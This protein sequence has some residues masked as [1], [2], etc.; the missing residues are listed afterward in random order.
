VTS[1]F[2]CTDPEATT[3]LAARIGDYLAAGDALLLHGEVGAGKSHFARGLI[4]SLL[5]DATR[6]EDIPSPTFTL[7]QTYE[8]AAGAP[9][10]HADLY[11]LNGADEIVELGLPDAFGEAIT[12]IEWPDRL[13]AYAPARRLE[14]TLEQSRIDADARCVSIVPVGANWDWLAGMGE[15]RSAL[16]RGFLSQAGWADARQTPITNDASNRRYTRLA[17]GGGTSILMDAP[18]SRNEDTRPFLA[19]GEYLRNRGYAAPEVFAADPENGLL[20]L[21]DLG[22]D[23]FAQVLS[24]RPQTEG[25]LY[26]T[27]VD[28]LVDL[29]SEPALQSLPPYATAIYQRESRLLLDWYADRPD[30]VDAFRTAL[31][32]ALARLSD[33]PAVTILRDYH[34]E[35]LLWLP[36]R[37][38][39]QRV[40]LLDFQDAL[41]GHPAYDLVSLLEDARR[42][43]SP[44]LAAEMKQRFATAKG[45]ALELVE[46]DCAI[47]GAQRNAKILGLFVRFARLHEKA[48]Y[49]AL[50]P[51][52]LAHFE[53]DLSHP[54]CAELRTVMEDAL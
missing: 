26:A 12:L 47:L 10:W 5:P 51:R 42:D 54:A 46:A 17:L 27:A 53:R 52:V 30:L 28:L 9:I 8:T 1:H 14:V 41:A 32:A 4:R 44:N 38:G 29:Q 20:L 21:E 11:R 49:L 7:V 40:G 23:L 43:V 48:Q 35:N 33:G 34:A 13:G 3:A 15:D 25:E 19:V 18:P 2:F 45:I 6:H 22:D 37:D 39:L 50:I 31:N 16:S 24:D 36:M